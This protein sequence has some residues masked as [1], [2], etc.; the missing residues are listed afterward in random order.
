MKIVLANNQPMQIVHYP[1]WRSG[2]DYQKLLAKA[3][4]EAD[5][6]VEFASYK[7]GVLPLFI[8]GRK[9]SIL[10]LHWVQS[11]MSTDV[12]W[13]FRF[14]T[15]YLLFYIDVL[16]VVF[17]RTRL[18]WTVHNIE[19]HSIKHRFLEPIARKWLARF[20]S[21]LIV[22]GN[23]IREICSASLNVPLNKISV[24]PHGSYTKEIVN[25]EN[26]ISRRRDW[27]SSEGFFWLNFGAVKPYKGIGWALPYWLQHSESTERLLI[28]GKVS[29]PYVKRNASISTKIKVIDRFIED[30][31]LYDMLSFCDAI[32]LP[33]LKVSTSGSL[34]HAISAGKPIVAPRIGS[35]VD[36]LGS[37]YP[38]LFSAGDADSLQT[39]LES[40]RNADPMAVL[41]LHHSLLEPLHWE[42]QGTKYLSLYRNLHSH[43]GV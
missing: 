14:I 22:H 30:W 21:A 6:Q 3:Q 34:I 29:D 10:H 20:C 43:E 39:A 23:S 42:K 9:A 15:R 19:E 25:R 2:N 35:V 1:D 38:F 36:Y 37:T 11:A 16:L 41:E 31:E 17:S 32:L 13:S 12:N 33:F 26:A 8:N 5:V 24:I 7:G 4:K 27:I 18:V 40:A 28:A